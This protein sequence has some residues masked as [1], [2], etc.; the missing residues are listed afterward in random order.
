LAAA[1]N[2]ERVVAAAPAPTPPTTSRLGI[3]VEPVPTEF[4]TARRLPEQYR[5]L[6]VANVE[7]G[8]PSYER[9]GPNDVIA[10]VLYP[11]PKQRVQSLDD[12]QRAL[13]RLKPGEILSLLVYRFQQGGGGT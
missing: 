2:E 12:L 10:E 4:V 5:G 8:S 9:L 3:S 11:Q 6:R 1:P 13:D 7:V